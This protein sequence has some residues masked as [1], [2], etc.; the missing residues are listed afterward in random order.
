MK[1]KMFFGIIRESWLRIAGL[2]VL[3]MGASACGVYLAWIS[4][5]VVDIATGQSEGSLTAVGLLL[6]AIIAIQLVLQIFLTVLHVNTSSYVRFKLQ[7]RLFEKFLNKQKLSADKFHSGELVNRLS[8][9][10]SI[11]ADGVAEILPSVMSIFARIL[12]SLAALIMLD[13]VLAVLCVAAGVLMLFA[14]KLY[15]VLSGDV[16]KKSRESEGHIRSFIQETAQNLAVIKAFSVHEIICRQ[17]IGAQ[18]TAYAYI[19]KKNRL[20]IGANVCFYIAMSIGY[21]A[22]LGWGAWRIMNGSI[23][24][25][26]LTAVLGLTNDV[27]TPFQQ[28]SSLLPQYIS[29]C[30]SAERLEELEFLPD[31]KLSDECDRVGMYEKLACV[32]LKDIAFSYG[33][34]SILQNVNTKFNKGKLT[35]I[36]GESG[37]GKSTLLNI[38]AGIISPS[39]GKTVLVDNDGVEYDAGAYRRMFAYVPQEFLLLS[40][41]VV[42]NITFFEDKPDVAR[43]NNAIKAAELSEVIENLPDGINTNLGEG[44]GRLSGGQ[45]QRM[46]IARALYTGADI[47]LMD[48]STSALSSETEKNILNNLKKDGKTVIFVTHRK[49]ATK[50]C[51]KIYRVEFGTIEE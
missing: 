7:A 50:L 9:D 41:D 31:D 1:N 4:K 44:G 22:V 33:E 2:S 32:R 29:V 19:V 45:R 25:G 3:G 21:Y 36:T 40:G 47:L 17:L 38:M 8:G 26:T 6:A 42:Q 14:A 10:T 37:A 27:T 49:S 20:G 24:F 11:V 13:P 46:A 18:K 28:L 12:L 5:N 48:E 34:G 51:D 23:T 16:F 43:F 35:A 39:Y 15:R 30:T